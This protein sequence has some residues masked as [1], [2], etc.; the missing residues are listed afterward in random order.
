MIQVFIPTFRKVED[1]NEKSYTVFC[2]EVNVSGRLYDVEKRYSEFEELHKKVKKRMATPEF[3]PKKV[4]K[5][6]SK[7]LEHRRQGLE[8][9]LQG[10]L[11][12][13]KIPRP[14]LSFLSIGHLGNYGSFDSLDQID[15]SGRTI[16]HQPVLAFTSGDPFVK[17]QNQG[18]LPDIV[19]QG[20]QM[21]LYDSRE[22]I[23]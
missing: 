14:V 18:N 5:W 3:P 2:I 22:F 21:G 20:V 12:L 11:S 23:T 17:E 7:V 9:Y 4:M 8:A 1:E 13:E 6:N 16:T 10:L 15:S 19:I